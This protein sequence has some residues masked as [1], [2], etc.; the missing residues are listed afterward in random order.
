MIYH[1]Q[2]NECWQK[3]WRQYLKAAPR[4][5]LEQ[6]W[7]Y[8]E[9]MHH[10]FGTKIERAVITENKE[11]VAIAQVMR[12]AG[13]T[14]LMRGPVFLKEL[15]IDATQQ[16]YKTIRQRYGWRKDGFLFWSPELT[17]T[18]EHK[19][20]LRQTR[21]WKLQKGYQ[22]AWL[23][24]RQD[25]TAMHQNLHGK[26]RNQ[27]R[28]AQRQGVTV[29]IAKSETQQAW[30]IQQYAVFR[31]SRKM[32]AP[33]GRFMEATFKAFA[34]H[35]DTLPLIAY[36]DDKSIAGTLFLQHG[37]SATYHMGVT[38]DIG[39]QYYAHNALLWQGICALQ[40]NGIQWL[41]MG[42][43][44]DKEMAGIGRF[45]R[46]LKGEEVTLAGLWF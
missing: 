2:W 16:I 13:V 24:L 42:G 3:Q 30:L 5:A 12:K 1:I 14:Q 23:D 11:P 46:G 41:D 36:Y 39:R 34:V 27:L 22:T 35:K 28:R 19:K 8:G 25:N 10:Y 9:A 21:L 32:A 26:W 15:S 4:S 31:K 33:S 17:D 20:L 37:N 18:P 44:N 45:K 6:S 29:K 7:C 38:T 43:F 40:D